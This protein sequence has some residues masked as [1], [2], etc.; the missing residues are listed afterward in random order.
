[1]LQFYAQNL[2][3]AGGS[4]LQAGIASGLGSFGS[5]LEAVKSAGI[6]EFVKPNVVYNYKS[7]PH[8]SLQWLSSQTKSPNLRNFDWH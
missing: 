2:N 6:S 4:K 3:I 7:Y 5:M 1:M 8:L